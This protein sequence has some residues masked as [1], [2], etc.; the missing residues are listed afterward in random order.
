MLKNLDLLQGET[1]RRV[2][3]PLNPDRSPYDLTGATFAMMARVALTDVSPVLSLSTAT[4]EITVDVAAGT[5]TIEISETV[6]ATLPY[7]VQTSLLYDLEMT[8]NGDVVRL[9][10]G[11]FVVKPEVTR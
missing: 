6:T 5:V 8:Q 11:N 1:W 3:R 7:R 9:M 10:Q 4:G 2:L